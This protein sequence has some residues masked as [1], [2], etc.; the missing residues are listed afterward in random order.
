MHLIGFSNFYSLLYLLLIFIEHKS[1]SFS[2]RKS[3]HNQNSREASSSTNDCCGQQ[4]ILYCQPA[5]YNQPQ[6]Y[7][8]DRI[9]Q[10]YPY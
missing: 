10:Q 6:Q 1:Q 2:E 4:N 8:H 5:D 9:T 3:E 7:C